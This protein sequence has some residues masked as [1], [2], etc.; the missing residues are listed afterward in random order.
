MKPMVILV[1]LY[2]S[3]PPRLIYSLG[4]DLPCP[5]TTNY[6]ALPETPPLIHSVLKWLAVGSN[7]NTPAKNHTFSTEHENY[8]FEF[9]HFNDR[10][11][12]YVLCLGQNTNVAAPY[13]LEAKFITRLTDTLPDMLWAKDT[14]GNY[15]FANQAI[16]EQ[17]LM[18]NKTEVI[19]K[20]DIMFALRERAKHPTNPKWHTFGETCVNSDEVV[21]K[22]QKAQRFEEFGFIKGKHVYLEVNKA[23]FYDENGVLIGVVGAARDITLQKQLEASLHNANKTFDDFLNLSLDAVALFNNQLQCVQVNNNFCHLTGY[24]CTEVENLSY[25]VLVANQ[26]APQ[27][28]NKLV[29]QTPKA[30]QTTLINKN[31]GLLPCMVRVKRIQI[32][33]QTLTMVAFVDVSEL[34][35]NRQQIEKV[36]RIAHTGNF[37][38]DLTTHTITASDETYRIYGLEPSSQ[39]LK[40]KDLLAFVHPH[41]KHRVIQY[42]LGYFDLDEELSI[43][44][45]IVRHDGSVRHITQN[46]VLVAGANSEPHLIVATT[47]DITD[48]VEAQ[49]KIL[50]QHESL[51][52][53]AHYDNLT[54][55]PNRTLIMERLN[56][57]LDVRNRNKIKHALLFIDLDHF[58]QINDSF[59][60]TFGDQV[61]IEVSKRLNHCI[62]KEDTLSRLGGDEFTLLLENIKDEF[63]ISDFIRHV[64]EQLN[65]PIKVNEI[66]F[67]ITLSIGIAIYPTDGHHSDELLKNADAAMYKAKEEGRN[68]YRFYKEEMT[69]KAFERLSLENNLREAIKKKSFEVFYQPQYN[70]ITGCIIGMEALIRWQH[71]S[72]GIIS[73]GSFLPFAEET[74]MI[75]TLDK[76][77]IKEAM[78]QFK[79]WIDHELE[80]GVL[81]LNLSMKLLQNNG[82]IPYITDLI[83]ALDFPAEQLEFEITESQIMNHPE[84]AIA[85]LIQLKNLGIRLSI[86]DFGTGY[87]SLSYLKRL[88]INKLKIDQSFIKGLPDDEEDITLTKTIINLA[89][90]LN[91]KV[92]AEGV[93]TKEQKDFV[94]EHGCSDIQGYYFSRPVYK[95]KIIKLLLDAKNK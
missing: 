37:E 90:N 25:L 59:G 19:G 15:L 95:D 88:P 14:K 9:N 18:A 57:L 89:K 71:P 1:Q 29:H 47:S 20:N 67:Y 66:P 34:Q 82:F 83:K 48:Q 6:Q 50:Q 3:K 44:Y 45:R 63:A 38:W 73:P 28:K 87:S 69:E 77:T 78:T 24:S 33:N 31:G 42:L 13:L 93:E 10:K 27:F 61:I 17:L 46:G 72:L 26:D 23:P 7:Q 39:P 65:N 70:G 62:R 55:L 21:L 94:I 11:Q 58:K 40:F 51:K 35:K 79:T 68:T 4:V 64:T 54:G 22:Q 30:L 92:I 43:T 12:R 52:Y 91:L 41:D 5:N 76:W 60:H 8:A 75:V 84:E 32:D 16:C 80:P 53:Q 86:D 2:E 81:A 56:H 85:K 74:G 36:Q 49:Q